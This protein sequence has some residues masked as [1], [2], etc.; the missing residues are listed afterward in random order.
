MNDITSDFL[1][2]KYTVLD[3]IDSSILDSFI[4]DSV[5]SHSRKS[6]RTDE[7]YNKAIELYAM[8]EIV[9]AFPEILQ[10]YNKSRE[11]IRSEEGNSKEEYEISFS[12]QSH[13][14]TYNVFWDLYQRHIRRSIISTR[15][16]SSF[17]GFV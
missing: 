8:S 7:A 5:A 1:L 3:G 2:S 15:I 9:S 11:K 10:K 13:L 17:Y 12:G 14:R 6:F 4:E 16:Y